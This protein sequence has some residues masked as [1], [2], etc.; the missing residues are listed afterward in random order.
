[1]P[2]DFV[3]GF[4]GAAVI[5]SSTVPLISSFLT[6]VYLRRDD[7]FEAFK[8]V[9]GHADQRH[10]LSTPSNLI[11]KHEGALQSWRIGCSHFTQP[12]GLLPR[13]GN[14]EC[15][16]GN[17]VTF[18]CRKSKRADSQ[19]DFVRAVCPRCSWASKWLA[20]P[21]WIIFLGTNYHFLH[22]Y[23]LTETQANYLRLEMAPP[24]GSQA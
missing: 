1:M 7:V 20:C 2:F 16:P 23:P 21:E 24:T 12:W 17:D 14:P 4:S 6:R 22:Q 3:L 9:F 15:T 8:D 10:T 13:C 11:V 19:H 18:K 5:P